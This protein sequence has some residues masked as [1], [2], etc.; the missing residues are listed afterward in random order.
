MRNRHVEVKRGGDITFAFRG[1]SGKHHEIEL[2]DSRI[3][4]IIRQCQ[5]M[6]GQILF[7]YLE[8][9]ETKHV[10]SQDV[11]EYLREIT[12]RDFTAKDFRTW[13]GT[14]LAAT[15]FQEFKGVVSGQQARRNV[16]LV[17]ESVS[18]ILGNTP[19]VCRKAYVHPEIIQSYLEG[20][21][22]ESLQQH[23]ADDLRESPHRLKPVETAV[24][25]LLQRRLLAAAR[26]SPSRLSKLKRL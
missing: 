1:K 22:I 9:G 6:P 20:R 12:G 19:A 25:A 14:V 15:A 8:D 2:H 26:R 21:T 13:I 11:N 16:N 5:E 24:L 4:K 18:K 7:S 17:I 10:G 3:A 23:V